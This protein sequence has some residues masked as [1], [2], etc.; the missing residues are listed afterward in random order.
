M[1]GLLALAGVG[2]VVGVVIGLV[3]LAGIRLLGIGGDDEGGR[4]GAQQSMY[5]PDPVRTTD[6]SGPRIT[7]APGDEE[8]S[9]EGSP[10]ASPSESEKAEK[11]ITLQSVQSSVAAMEQ[12]D[13]TGVYPDGEG[14]ILQVERFVDG[15]WTD[16]P[17]TASV[18]GGT[19]STYVQT[20]QSGENR[21]RMRDTSNGEL[22]NEVKVRVG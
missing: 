21:F 3:A 18:S 8:S 15:G 17:V 7:L 12:I 9:G 2:V 14:A 4:A 11:G 19:F 5:I 1:T 22:S 13:L 20:G 16:F 6:D 10:S